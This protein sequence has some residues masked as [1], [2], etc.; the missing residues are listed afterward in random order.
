MSKHVDRL[1]AAALTSAAAL[2]SVATG[3]GAAA[4]ASSPETLSGVQ[5]KAVAAITL[6]VN[7]LNSTIAK[8]NAGKGLGSGQATL[9]AYLERDLSP[10]QQLGTKIAGDPSVGQ[11][12]VD[13]Q[14]IFTNFRVLAL[15]LP[16]AEQAADADHV[17]ATAVPVLTADASKAESHVTSTNQTTLQPMID[18]LNGDISGA[19]NA[20]SGLDSSV[21]SYA[22]SQWNANHALLLPTKAS[23][24]TADTDIKNGRNEV[25]QIKQYLKSWR[26]AAK[27][28][29]GASP[30]SA[31]TTPGG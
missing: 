3:A 14:G 23:L 9:V 24:S 11:A 10:L 27:A 2:A 12:E 29:P 31:P 18:A 16:A 19:S 28:A 25:Q 1:G 17:T 21:L 15:V 26:T 30:S 4:R 7:D 20:S 6:R 22:P 13:Y 8:V 5:T